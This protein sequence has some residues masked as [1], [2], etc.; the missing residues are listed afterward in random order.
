LKGKKVVFLKMP[1]F[2]SLMR[3]NTKNY[4][5][6]VFIAGA[7]GG[8]GKALVNEFSGLGFL[9]IATDIDTAK[10]DSISG[11]PNVICRKLD[12]TDPVSITKISEDLGLSKTGLDILVSQA[13]IYKTFPVTEADPSQLKNIIDVNLHGT[14]SMIQGLLRPLIRNKGRV[15]VVSSESYKLQALFQ[16]Y[17][18]SKAA[19]E[20]Y[21]KTARQ[22]L[23]LKG[24][25][26][27]VIRPG[28]MRTPLLDWMK[29]SGN[30]EKYPV[31]ENE[32][33]ASR[34]QSVKMVG[35][36]IPPEKV[37]RLIA[38]AATASYPR[39]VYRINNSLLLNLI[40]LLPG[41]F[42]DKMVIKRFKYK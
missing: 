30:P 13:G 2:Q 31:Y 22:E 32:Y 41:G 34:N 5:K 18:I 38:R 15:I 23:A 29:S 27:T 26:L 21:C 17:M 20:A 7:G 35:K 40:S 42:F 39:R 3:T 14:S 11:V 24:V 16:P 33:I 36:A 10:L 9:V 12:V 28:A 6:I 19:L 8:L 1:Q 4:Q 25:K 37:A